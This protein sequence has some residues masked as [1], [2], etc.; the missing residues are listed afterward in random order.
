ME[1][2]KPILSIYKLLEFKHIIRDDKGV[3]EFYCTGVGDELGN[4]HYSLIM[5]F[6][7]PLVN[8]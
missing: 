7:S 4:C 8:G 5:A 2:I 1:I 6:I 3:R